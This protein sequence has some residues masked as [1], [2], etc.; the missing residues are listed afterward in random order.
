MKLSDNLETIYTDA[1]GECR[2]LT[3]IVLPD[4]VNGMEH[5]VFSGNDRI[6]IIYKGKSYTNEEFET[7][8]SSSHYYGLDI[9]LLYVNR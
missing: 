6:T 4:S 9:K 1:F 3:E 5:N 2:N 7:A 8:L